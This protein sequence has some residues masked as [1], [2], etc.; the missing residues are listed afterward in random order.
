VRWALLVVIACDAGIPPTP[1]AAPTAPAPQPPSDAS[2]A[3]ASVDAP[4]P[5]AKKKSS[6]CPKRDLPP[7][8][9]DVFAS[10]RRWGCYGRCPVYQVLVYRDG[11]VELTGI[12]Y[13]KKC[14]ASGRITANKMRELHRMFVRHKFAALKDKY[15][16]HDA[17][18]H[19]GA[20]ISFMPHPDSTR[21]TVEHYHG[22]DDAP[23]KLLEIEDAIDD[24]AGTAEWIYGDD[25]NPLDDE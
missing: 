8:T 25:M 1:V 23:R 12:A 17:T 15:V 13:V 6:M 18:D 22:D 4:P 5:A 7:I 11:R 24:I 9:D 14:E 19:P 3:D 10:M 20:D 21:K 16:D 2:I